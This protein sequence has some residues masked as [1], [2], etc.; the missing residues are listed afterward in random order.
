[1]RTPHVFVNK[2]AVQVE[3]TVGYGPSIGGSVLRFAVVNHLVCR[4]TTRTCRLPVAMRSIC[5]LVN[6]A[7]AAAFVDT[8]LAASTD[9]NS[10]T[11][12]RSSRAI[13]RCGESGVAMGRTPHA[14]QL[15]IA[16]IVAVSKLRWS[17]S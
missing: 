13:R 1:M 15:W 14:A 3:A 9:S 4:D 5:F 12:T 17:S 2:L 10:K 11:L 16:G 6:K 7:A 8:A